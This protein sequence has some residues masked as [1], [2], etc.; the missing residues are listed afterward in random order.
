MSGGGGIGVSLAAD[1]LESDSLVGMT[2][3]PSATPAP[4]VAGT[5]IIA[6][7]S[8][9]SVPH[10][11]SGPSVS[12]LSVPSASLLL[13][14][15]HTPSLE[16]QSNLLAADFDH[17]RAA[18]AI[19][20]VDST[21]TQTNRP[22]TTNTEQTEPTNQSQLGGTEQ[23]DRPNSVVI[24]HTESDSAVDPAPSPS[25]SGG[26]LAPSAA[27]D[28]APSGT[29]VSSVVVPPVDP[30]SPSAVVAGPI[31]QLKYLKGPASPIES[32]SF[33]SILTVWW[34]SAL[35]VLGNLR[36]LDDSDI[37]EMPAQDQ[38]RAVFDK[39]HKHWMESRENGKDGS[40]IKA[41]LY[42]FGGMWIQG[43]AMLT[44]SYVFQLLQP[45]FV[46]EIVS[47]LKDEDADPSVGYAWCGALIAVTALSSLFLNQHFFN[48]I[49][50]GNA[51]RIACL[52]AIYDKSLK[53]SRASR[54][55]HSTGATV[56][57]MSNDTQRIFDCMLILHFI[58][59]APAT[60]IVALGLMIS[61]VGVAAIAG[62]GLFCLLSPLQIYISR[63][64]GRN[65]REM[66]QFS[67]HRVRLMSEVLQGIRVVKLYAWEEAIAK[68]IEAIRQDELKKVK[69]SLVLNAI[70]QS[71]LFVMPALVAAVIMCVYA[72]LGNEVNVTNTFAI[73]AYLN[74]IRNPTV[75]IPMTVNAMAEAN[76]SIKRIH[77]FLTLAELTPRPN[78]P[79]DASIPYSISVRNGVFLWSP[80]QSTP[81]LRD[82]TLNIKPG[83]LVA[84]IGAVGCGKVGSEPQGQPM[85]PE[86]RNRGNESR[87][88]SLTTFHTCSC[89]CLSLVYSVLLAFRPAW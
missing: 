79:F 3:T 74:I 80:D 86:K 58:W 84:I 15:P 66:L 55:V 62:V 22:N 40:I 7:P 43:G 61:E 24:F 49:R 30:V 77:S 14:S 20:G 38:T 41:L 32:A 50:A 87:L 18:S 44:V 13:A 51:A 83:A 68:K 71:I 9:L 39:F 11:P 85:E 65:R 78:L 2:V 52:A 89:A 5:G 37:P 35:I 25:A 28:G 48:L 59:I 53:L 16:W 31:S 10:P 75:L 60:I 1:P 63:L 45:I 19:E 67:D 46:Q 42:S 70:N 34:A 82:I 47:F 57:I 69:I 64:T 56:N 23:V 36:P 12:A 76:V 21:N 29:S 4:A 27:S 72:A 26:L 81:A 8:N 54:Q 88:T 6:P 33:L 73:L 17:S